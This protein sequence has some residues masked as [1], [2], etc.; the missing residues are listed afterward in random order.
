MV[1]T[2]NSSSPN[3]YAALPAFTSPLNSLKITFW[4]AMENATYGTLTVGY[5][6]DR[7]NLASSFVEVEAIPSISHSSATATDTFS[8]DFA[9]AANIPTDGYICFRWYKDGTYYSCC[10]DDIYVEESTAPVVE[11]PTV[12]T[13]PATG[14][15]QTTATLN[16][17]IVTTGDL[18][19]SGCGFEW[20]ANTASEYTVVNLS[21]TAATLTHNLTGLNANTDY[22]YRAFATTANGTF[23]GED[24]NFRTLEEGVDP[25]DAPTNLQVTNITQNTATMTW[26][27][28]GGETSWQVGYKTQSASQW[29]DVPATTTSYNLE[30]LSA[31]TTYNVR[32]RAIC[33][34]NESD[35][36]TSS[37]ITEG[38][39]IDNITL[40]NSISLQPNPADNYIELSIN[41][42]VEVKEAVIYNAFGQK[43]QTVELNNNHARIDLGNM[44][45]GMY[46]VRVNGDNTTATKKFI[47]K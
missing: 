32:V 20:K 44:A 42:N 15:A 36:V 16:G 47:K 27:P 19:I 17:A 33:E 7:N 12:A 23:Y 31:N 9:A 43:I 8:V 34:N 38:V 45:A 37:F 46:F 6:T 5:V 24:V 26:T 28:G 30:G 18:P 29:T 22:T 4:R 3:A 2:S 14:I 25:C 39:G 1:F 40:A 13:Y 41:S 21:S 10:I 35:Y 11:D